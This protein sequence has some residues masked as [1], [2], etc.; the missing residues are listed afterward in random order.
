MAAPIMRRPL[1]ALLALVIALTLVPAS[2]SAQEAPAVT[3]TLLS[4]TPWNSSYDPEQGRDLVVRFRADNRGDVPIEDLSIGVAVYGRVISRSAFEASLTADPLVVIDADSFIR[5]DALM[6]GVPRDFEIEFPLDAGI[7]PDDSG[8]YPVKIELRSGFTS[9]AAIRSAV[10]FLVREPELPL[11]LSWT[12]VLQQPI[13]VGPDGTFTSTALEEALGPEGRLDAQIRA[14]LGLVADPTM[15]AVD[16]AVAPTLLLQLDRMSRGY[17]VAT[18]TGVR[19]VPAGE[20]GSALALQ[21]LD[22]LRGIAAAPNVLVTALPYASPEFPSLLTGGLGR[23]VPTQIDRGRQVVGELIRT[24]PA[25]SIVRPPGAALD[26]Q[27]LE[28]LPQFGVSTLVAGPFTVAPSPQPLGFAGPPTAG[29][30]GDGGLEAI[31]PEPGVM[32]RLQSPPTLDDPVLT[33]QTVLGEL[34]T[35]WQEQ[36]GVER[37]LGLVVSEDLLAQPAFY[38]ALA[39]N[40]AG[41]PWLRTMHAGEF[42]LRFPPAEA[43]ALTSP[44][45][46]TFGSS[47]VS[48]LRRARRNVDVFRSML[49]EPSTLP[50]EYEQLLLL[51]ES[52]QFL[53]SPE[54]GLAFIGHVRDSTAAVFAAVGIDTVEEITLAS[55][56]G[57]PIPVTVLNG[58]DEAL[59]VTVELHSSRLEGTPSIDLEL[60]AASSET[61]TFTVDVRSTGVFT[62]EVQVAAPTGRVIEVQSFTVRSTVYNRIALFITIGAAVLLLALWA[63]RFLPR[64]TS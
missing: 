11:S 3:L 57:S 28:V 63:R 44:N 50:D 56:T 15:P 47:Y 18:A 26:D 40:V 20:G 53:S 17:S 32:A 48:E 51:A 43:S 25:T 36:P 27:T 21:A 29:L 12:F 62:V 23:D 59:R 46:R 33:A 34:A 7:D 55:S 8:V 49:A 19:E 58:S 61:V 10:V 31:V 60:A 64:R 22:D 52:R 16:V 9:L 37:G 38:G 14:L 45:P 54:G 13:V 24:A 2:A 1:P 42:V 6:P 41:A 5:E 30:G 4:Q 39:R 35:I